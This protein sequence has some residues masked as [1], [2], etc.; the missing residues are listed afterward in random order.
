MPDDIAR[1]SFETALAEL[2]QI[3]RTLE[4]GDSQ[5]E[6]AISLYE[7]GAQL[8]RHCESQLRS[9]QQKIERIVLSESGDAKATASLDPDQ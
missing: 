2:E 5:L 8:K 9:A 6:A 1:M 3:V 4:A 7:R